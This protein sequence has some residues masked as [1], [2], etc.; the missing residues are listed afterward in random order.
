MF[1]DELGHIHNAKSESQG[2]R[3]F[4]TLSH[5]TFVAVIHRSNTF[6]HNNILAWNG[7]YRRRNGSDY[8]YT[9][10]GRKQDALETIR[11]PTI[12]RIQQA[13]FFPDHGATTQVSRPASQ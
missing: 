11:Y 5:K 2:P 4:T 8:S 12:S 6:Q 10:A 7:L 3:F 1:D 9:V 13:L